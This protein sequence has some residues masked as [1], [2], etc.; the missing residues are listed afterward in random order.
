MHSV[1]GLL[2]L[3]TYS[4]LFGWVLIEQGG[5]PI[6]SVP[7]MLA[8]GT[9]SAAHKLHARLRHPDHPLGLLPLRLRLVLP[10]QALRRPR[11]QRPLPLLAGGRHLR[12]AH[13]WH[14]RQ[15]RSLHPALR[16]VRPR[17]QHRRRAHRRPAPDPVP[18]LRPL[19]HDSARSSGAGAWLFAGRFFGD[20][21]KRSA[22]LLRP[23]RPL[24]HRPGSADGRRPCS[25]TAWSSAA[26]SS[27]SSAACASN[28]SSSWP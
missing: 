26:S 6:P 25:S 7:L 9:M 17:P 13:P 19:R 18:H 22:R 4:I 16:Q 28:P 12:R 15:A 10:R 27:P 1:L 3:H 8:A 14:R 20:I 23:P 24:R 5:L 11:A 21:A 2:S